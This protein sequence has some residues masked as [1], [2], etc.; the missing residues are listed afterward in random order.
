MGACNKDTLQGFR[1][2]SSPTMSTLRKHSQ[3]KDSNED[4]TLTF[5]LFTQLRCER[6]AHLVPHFRRKFVLELP[7]HYW[8]KRYLSL[9]AGLRKLFL[10]RHSIWRINYR[11]GVQF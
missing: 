4:N 3:S 1:S 9:S 6:Y 2:T 8:W 11:F 7:F 5:G 10:F